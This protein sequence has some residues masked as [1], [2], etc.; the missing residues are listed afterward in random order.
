MLLGRNLAPKQLACDV[1]IDGDRER[2]IGSC[3]GCHG[4]RDDSME[5]T[6]DVRRGD[7]ST[8]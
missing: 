2:R 7:V 1:G 8:R 5:P 3:L 6:A 4:R